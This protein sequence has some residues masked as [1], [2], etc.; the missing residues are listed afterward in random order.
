MQYFTF[1]RLYLALYQSGI[2]QLLLRCC[3]TVALAIGSSSDVP[4]SNN[5]PLRQKSS[6]AIR[7]GCPNALAK[8][9]IRLPD[10]T[11]VFLFS[12]VSFILLFAKVM[13]RYF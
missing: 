1:R 10:S 12:C 8:R 11:A 9:A 6:I 7:A 2:L 5:C 4:E 3:D 13:K